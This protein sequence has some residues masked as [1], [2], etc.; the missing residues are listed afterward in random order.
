MDLYKFEQIPDNKVAPSWSY[1]IGIDNIFTFNEC[2][3]IKNILLDKEISLLNETNQN[4]D[5]DIESGIIRDGG[6]GLGNSSITS[7]FIYFNVLNWDYDF[8][9]KLK[10][11]L[12]QSIKIY[13]QQYELS[14]DECYV[15]CWFNVLRNGQKILKHHHSDHPYT[16]IGGHLTICTQETHT[17]YENPFTNEVAKIKNTI[18]DLTLFPNW[19]KHWTDSYEGNDV[20]ISIA[21]DVSYKKAIDNMPD[22]P[23]KDKIEYCI[24]KL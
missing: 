2:D 11:H 3:E 17:Y 1:F 4:L 20:R 8:S 19:I 9:N 13:L 6:T 23:G 7:R 15:K 24:L 14:Y 22:Y 18:G 10:K 21:L 5:Q 16:L 12:N